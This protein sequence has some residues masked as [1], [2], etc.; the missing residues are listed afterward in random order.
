VERLSD[1][2]Q[3][4]RF[5]LGFILRVVRRYRRETVL[6]ILAALL[7]MAMVIAGPYLTKLVVDEAITGGQRDLLA[8][9]VGLVLLAGL[10]RAL[11]I[12]GRRY[13][14]FR[15]SYRAETDLRN[16]I[17]EHIQRLAF[18][19]HDRISTGELMARASTDL[20]QF[21]IVLAM[22]PITVAN[23]A[24]LTAVSVVLIVIDPVLGAITAVAIPALLAVSRRYAR[25]VLSI[26]FEVQQSLADIATDVEEAV[27]G[28]RVVKSYGREEHE[29]ARVAAT[30]DRI[31]DRAIALITQRAIHVP[32]FEA[33]PAIA[34]GMVLLVGGLRVAG[35][36][37]TLGDFVAFTEYM[38]VLNFPL[39]ITGFFL[40]EL[41]RASA[42]A[43]RIRD[44]LA[45]APDITNPAQPVALPPGRGRVVFDRVSFNYP[46]GPAVLSEFDLAV[47]A[48]KSVA[49][50]GATGSGK[51]TVAYLLPRFYDPT[52]GSI[53]LDGADI[54][55][56]AL[57]DLR[58]AVAVAFEEPFL[59]SAS[60]R[61]N[62]AFGDPDATD[63]QVRLAAR[64]ASA[65]GFISELSDGY[66]TVVGERGFSLSGGQ[67]QR[68]ALARAVLRDPRVLILDDAMSSVDAATEQEI[69][70][71]LRTVMA[72]RTTIIIAHRPA[73]LALADEVVFLDAGVVAAVG[74]HEDLLATVPRYAEVLAEQS[75]EVA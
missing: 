12:G 56:L 31:F 63:E 20:S 4:I 64:L 18:S 60:I 45:T 50:V 46:D 19:F 1:E 22:L 66:D 16:R 3:A 37:I 14:A 33:L 11:G 41:P 39:R 9:L 48:G 40:A 51:S 35:G 54:R 53:R 30:S 2:P 5:G 6:S 21:R 8:P 67:R 28:I 25:R 62:I 44:L 32:L 13:F 7:W 74:A 75:A 69:R 61:E 38:V 10:A 59:F 26:S 49:L 23:L 52:A 57:E 36:I 17:F 68:I 34:T 15:L 43:V 27:S 55:S 72:G 65:D 58:S 24:L 71:S 70:D 73:T 29:V 47:D 42:A